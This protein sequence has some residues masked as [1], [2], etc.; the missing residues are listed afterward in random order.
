MEYLFV[1][2][3]LDLS[4][5]F[6]DNTVVIRDTVE[7]CHCAFCFFDTSF[8]IGISRAFREEDDS[9]PED[10]DPEERYSHGDSPTSSVVSFLGTKIDAICDKD[11]KR[12]E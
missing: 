9:K 10:Q 1:V 2:L 12:N 11:A 8:A 6:G 4:Q 7:L 3:D 5:F